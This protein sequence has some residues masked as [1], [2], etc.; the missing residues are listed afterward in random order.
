MT[1]YTLITQAPDGTGYR[2][3]GAART[4]RRIIAILASN[5]HATDVYTQ[6]VRIVDA[7]GTRYEL[8]RGR[9]RMVKL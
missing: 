8:D 6:G 3:L 2:M 1:T 7:A 5:A 9:G 4:V